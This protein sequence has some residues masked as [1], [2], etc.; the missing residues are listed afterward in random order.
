[1]IMRNLKRS[2]S[3]DNSKGH[4]IH[5]TNLKCI[6]TLTDHL[7]GIQKI[8]YENSRCVVE[9]HGQQQARIEDQPFLHFQMNLTDE[10]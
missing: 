4:L 6:K 8:L 9:G 5:C 1:M 10:L 2:M 7:T 3:Y